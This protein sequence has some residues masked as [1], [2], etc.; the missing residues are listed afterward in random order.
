[1]MKPWWARFSQRTLR[2]LTVHLTAIGPSGPQVPP[3]R[4]LASSVWTNE[5][6]LRRARVGLPTEPMNTKPGSP[7]PT[8]EGGGGITSEEHRSC[9]GGELGGWMAMPQSTL[10]PSAV[11][12]GRNEPDALAAE[13]PA[14]SA[15]TA[16]AV[17]RRVPDP[18][19]SSHRA[20]ALMPASSHR[21][22][23]SARPRTAPSR[24]EARCGAARTPPRPRG[25]RRVHRRRAQGCE[26]CT[27]CVSR[28]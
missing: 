21:S 13:E 18:P 23:L 22:R 3:G 6:W 28:R 1:M 17:P 4:S 25:S 14:P 19:R 8:P 15:R 11:Q 7:K 16:R 26:R 27:R 2:E 12:K 24:G 20:L 5:S 9:I 10:P